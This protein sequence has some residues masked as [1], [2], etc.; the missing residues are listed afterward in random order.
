M[1][2]KT[3]AAT[4]S[5][6]TSTKK[7][8][9]TPTMIISMWKPTRSGAKNTQ[10]LKSQ[11]CTVAKAAKMRKTVKVYWTMTSQ[12]NERHDTAFFL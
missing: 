9:S 11:T 2:V 5:T 7:S 10:T 8:P 1:Q 6:M 4:H 3:Q 12:I